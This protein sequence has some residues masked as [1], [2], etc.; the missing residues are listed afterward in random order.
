MT[1]QLNRFMTHLPYMLSQPA[2][3]VR[4][5]IISTC[6]SQQHRDARDLVPAG[7]P[8][9]AALDLGGV[10]NLRLKWEDLAELAGSPFLKLC[11][12]GSARHP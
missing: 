7:P 5:I 1:E 6:I 8:A 11:Q 9:A 12:G 3:A 4:G 2:A 10:D